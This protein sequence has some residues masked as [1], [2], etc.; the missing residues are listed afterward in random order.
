MGVVFRIG[1]AFGSIVCVLFCVVG[2][3]VCRIL[4]V[5]LRVVSFLWLVVFLCLLLFVGIV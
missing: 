4:L 5:G 1:F 2:V 3:L